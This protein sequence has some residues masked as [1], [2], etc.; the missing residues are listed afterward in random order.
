[1][2]FRVMGR[3]HVNL[4][5]PTSFTSFTSPSSSPP[6]PKPRKLSTAFSARRLA[7][8]TSGGVSARS[9]PGRAPQNPI[10]LLYGV[11]ATLTLV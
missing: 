8:S 6:P 3:L 7:A 1:M 11:R 4:Y 10:S 9:P 2:H 5:S